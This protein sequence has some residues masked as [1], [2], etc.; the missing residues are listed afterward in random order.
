[1]QSL[2]HWTTGKSPKIFILKKKNTDYKNYEEID[3]NMCVCHTQNISCKDVTKTYTF[4][5]GN[6]TSGGF[7][8]SCTF[9]KINMY[10]V[11]NWGARYNKNES[12]HN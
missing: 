9:S 7:L 8:T 6:K 2:N 3:L 5:V 10:Y 12:V 4:S 1:M 11:Q